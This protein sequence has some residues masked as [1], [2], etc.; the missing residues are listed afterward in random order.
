MPK[1]DADVQE[2]EEDDLSRI[3]SALKG[4][5]LDEATLRK[6]IQENP[7][8]AGDLVVKFLKDRDSAT[9]ALVSRE[10][11]R[12]LREYRAKLAEEFP[13]ADV[14]SLEGTSK[15]QIRAAAERQHKH[16]ERIMKAQGVQPGAKAKDEPKDDVT[17]DERQWGTAPAGA[18]EVVKQGESMAWAALQGKAETARGPQG[19][20]AKRA[21]LDA[22]KADGP[23]VI[24]RPTL[25]GALARRAAAAQQS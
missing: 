12:D 20:Q 18:T 9:A 3:E 25:A 1:E 21:V 6:L 8:A 7:D 14:D 23:R 10:R 22:I 4:S 13:F 2:P 16:I 24:T 17:R 11:N 15:K 19:D 5:T